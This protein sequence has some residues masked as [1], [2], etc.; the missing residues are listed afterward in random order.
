MS[1]GDHPLADRTVDDTGSRQRGT[2]LARPER[3]AQLLDAALEVFVQK[4]YHNAVVD[5]IADRAGVSKPV[6]YQHFPGKLELYL[7]LL[8]ESTTAM[9]D[10]VR[11]ALDSTQDNK[12][13]VEATMA[14]YFGFVGD[15]SG[16][17]RLLFESDLVHDAEVRERVTRAQHE[18][19]RLVS[20]VIAA[21]TNLGPEESMLL[22]IGLIGMAQVSAR[23]ALTTDTIASG[24]AAGLLSQLTWRGISGFPRSGEHEESSTGP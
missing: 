21:D 6:V 1:A 5:D 22:A 8:D 10:A 23:W 13:R 11:A 16:A 12:Q 17:H 20:E 3:R 7:A 9:I 19:A 24:P 4:G 2:R 14:A 18:C 15:D